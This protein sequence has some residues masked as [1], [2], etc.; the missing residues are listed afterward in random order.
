M[1]FANDHHGGGETLL[2]SP[3]PLRRTM[4]RGVSAS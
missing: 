2:G 4:A 3:A 1:S